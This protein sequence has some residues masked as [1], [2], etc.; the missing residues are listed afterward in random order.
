M[1][2]ICNN[3]IDFRILDS[4]QLYIQKAKN[5][6]GFDSKQ[7]MNAGISNTMKWYI[8]FLG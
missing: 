8:D 5:I 7:N 4:R 3:Y 1:K 2:I 6:L